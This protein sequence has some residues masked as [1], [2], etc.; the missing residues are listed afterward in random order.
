MRLGA[1]YRAAIGWHCPRRHLLSDYRVAT[2]LKALPRDSAA[3][4]RD[5]RGKLKAHIDG[6]AGFGYDR[7]KKPGEVL[8][9]IAPATA[10]KD[11]INKLKA[12]GA[13]PTEEYVPKNSGRA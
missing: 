1:V 8:R 7:E 2:P 13:I 6:C 5:G 12:L 10:E 9:V 4:I 3:E 11:E